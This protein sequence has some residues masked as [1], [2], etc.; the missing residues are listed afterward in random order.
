MRFLIGKYTLFKGDSQSCMNG[1]SETPPGSCRVCIV[2]D[3]GNVLMDKL[4]RQ[5]ER[6]TDF[7]TKYSGI[8]PAD[9]H[10]SKAVPLEEVQEEAA[11]LMKD[12]VLVG[13]AIQNDLKVFTNPQ[14]EACS[15]YC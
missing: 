7:R 8:R 5:K 15:P 4:V 2:N 13:H 12:R 9:L 10:E 11:K 3:E 1:W 6:V 14:L